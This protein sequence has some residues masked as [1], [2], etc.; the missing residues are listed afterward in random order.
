MSKPTAYTMR[1]S[2]ADGAILSPDMNS[3][4]ERGYI[5]IL[6]YTDATLATPATPTAG[7]ITFEGSESNTGFGSFDKGVVDLTAATYDRPNFSG[8]VRKVRATSLGVVG[9]GYF[10]ATSAR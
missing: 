2:T 6:F 9:A 10:V 5:S 7:T 4:L 8:S 3:F 1:G